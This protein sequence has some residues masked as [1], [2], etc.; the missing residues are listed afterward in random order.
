MSDLDE[1]KKFLGMTIQR[2]RETKA[3]TISQEDY[4][5]KI[6]LKF[7][8]EKD[9]PKNTPMI[10]RQVANH[11]RRA[12]EE[13]HNEHQKDCTLNIPYREAISSLLY[14]SGATRPDIAYAVNVLSRHQL[15][16]TENE[17]NM[18]KRVFMYL[19]GTQSMGLNYLGP[20]KD[21]LA[22]SDA[23][24]SDCKS[25]I[26]TCGFYSTHIK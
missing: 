15:S 24:F 11:E 22:Y 20:R 26:S 19:K 21:F 6:L 12:R 3:M 16:P 17:W 4:I 1:P 7:G 9:F 18:V 10:T 5:N 8:F 13:D 25:S 2:D 14:L 23:S